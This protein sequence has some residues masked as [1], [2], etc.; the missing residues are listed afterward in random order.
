MRI[1]SYISRTLSRWKGSL[2]YLRQ[3]KEM[4]IDH[5][6]AAFPDMSPCFAM[7]NSGGRK[8]GE[9]ADL[10]VLISVDF[11]NISETPKSTILRQSSSVKSRLSGLISR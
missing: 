2:P 3:Y 1:D 11:S 7:H 4:P 5:I 9:P 8:A 10:A 6:S